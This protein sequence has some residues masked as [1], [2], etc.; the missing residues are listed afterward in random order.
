MERKYNLEKIAEYITEISD[1]DLSLQMTSG[2]LGLFWIPPTSLMYCRPWDD[3]TSYTTLNTLPD[4]CAM[5]CT[6][7]EQ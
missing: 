6:E 1:L 3:P 2:R 7:D 5:T 4:V